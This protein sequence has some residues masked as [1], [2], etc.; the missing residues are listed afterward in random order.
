[1]RG[2]P[3]LQGLFGIRPNWFTDAGFARVMLLI[4]DTWLGYPSM[5]LLVIGVLQSAPE[6][7]SATPWQTCC[8]ICL[9]LAVPIKS[10]VFVLAFIGF[11]NDYPI[12]SVLIWSE[13]NMTLA[14]GLRRRRSC[15]ARRS[16]WWS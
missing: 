11:I 3:I 6:I 5:L 1:M 13:Q 2:S 15:R 7:D 14:V 12:A 4:G 10:V 8:Y 16:P 9:T